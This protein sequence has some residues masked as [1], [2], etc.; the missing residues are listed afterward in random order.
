MNAT[1]GG[2]IWPDPP[3]VGPPMTET[4]DR[5]GEAESAS[6]RLAGLKRVRSGQGGMRKK[7]AGIIKKAK[8]SQEIY[9]QF[10]SIAAAFACAETAVMSSKKAKGLCFTA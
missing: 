5:P 2:A 8:N 3:N 9:Q 6:A 4:R 7:Y 1:T 10:K